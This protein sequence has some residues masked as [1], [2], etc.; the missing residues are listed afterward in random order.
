MDDSN[1]FQRQ[2]EIGNL[3]KEEAASPEKSQRYLIV[4]VEINC[5]SP[6]L[7]ISRQE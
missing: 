2:G 1:G 4:D 3:L 6:T 7:K 5:T